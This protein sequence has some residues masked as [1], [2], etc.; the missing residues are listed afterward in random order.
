M[1]QAERVKFELIREGDII[2]V[3]V[4]TGYHVCKVIR[5]TESNIWYYS[6]K[7]TSNDVNKYSL[8]YVILK[9]QRVIKKY[10]KYIPR[11]CNGRYD[12]RDFIL[13]DNMNYLRLLN[14]PV[15]PAQPAQPAQPV[16]PVQIPF[17]PEQPPNA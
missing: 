5:R 15:Q 16:Q 2:R 1:D 12:D 10:N 4:G 7:R 14:Q 3:D 13:I 6:L 9:E 11:F 8:Y 17:I